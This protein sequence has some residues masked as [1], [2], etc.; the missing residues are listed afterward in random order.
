MP[1]G[2]AVDTV[3]T[4]AYVTT[5]SQRKIGFHLKRR[6]FVMT[7]LLPDT[8]YYIPSDQLIRKFS[9]VINDS[10]GQQG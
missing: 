1:T 3:I 8:T 5:A 10:R 4:I 2:S 6:K 7:E 9:T